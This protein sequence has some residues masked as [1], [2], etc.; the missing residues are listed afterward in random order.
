MSKKAAVVGS[1]G[2]SFEFGPEGFTANERR[3]VRETEKGLPVW[4]P[5]GLSRSWKLA[6]LPEKAKDGTDMRGYLAGYGL[7]KMQQDRC[8][9]FRG[10][11]TS[12]EYL[13][14]LDGVFQQLMEGELTKRRSGGKEAGASMLIALAS[15]LLKAGKAQGE[16][17][18]V[19]LELAKL[20]KETLQAVC[21]LYEKELAEQAKDSQASVSLD[22]Q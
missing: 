17:G 18:A 10:K 13:E 14:L 19:A 8:S 5:T 4:E 22:I 6:D 21:K 1:L 15:V 7:S 11:V 12:E 9:Q 16:V 2:F 20:P 3:V